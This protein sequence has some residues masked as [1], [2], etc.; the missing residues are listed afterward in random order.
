MDQRFKEQLQNCIKFYL[1]SPTKKYPVLYDISTGKNITIMVQTDV[2]NSTLFNKDEN[3]N[4][5]N[6]NTELKKENEKLIEE[7]KKL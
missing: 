5:N 1:P 6:I 7:I 2:S 4:R 3:S